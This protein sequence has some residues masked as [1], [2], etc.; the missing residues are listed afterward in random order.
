MLVYIAAERLDEVCNT[1]EPWEIRRSELVADRVT[2]PLEWTYFVATIRDGA[3]RL[4]AYVE[5]GAP[6]RDDL[7][8]PTPCDF[9]L[10]PL[11][12][13][14]GCLGGVDGLVEWAR[15]P[16]VLAKSDDDLLRY[17]LG[18]PLDVAVQ[19]EPPPKPLPKPT[20]F[21]HDALAMKLL[22]AVYEDPASDANR[23]VLA[24]RLL[25]LGDPRGE[26]IALQ[27]GR[28]QSGA[29]ASERERDLIT[30]YGQIWAQ[31]IARCLALYGFRR[32]F[33][34]TAVVA[35][36]AITDPGLIEHPAWAT[37]EELETRSSVFVYA[38]GMRGVRRLATSGDVLLA[39]ADGDHEVAVEAI[40]GASIPTGSGRFVQGGVEILLSRVGKTANLPRLHSMSIS[41]EDPPLAQRAMQF[42]TS[43][44]GE[45][46]QHVELF[47][48][49]L[50][51]T[52]VA[53]WR[54]IYQV[55]RPLSLGLRGVIDDWVVAIVRQRGAITVQLGDSSS[56]R[57]PSLQPIMRVINAL[58]GKLTSLTLERVGP[59]KFGTSL[60]PVVAELERGFATVTVAQAASWRSP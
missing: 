59:D 2:R 41:I 40:V 49:D 53:P 18:L 9:D 28:V 11:L 31:P 15:W 25:D 32:G 36:R 46:L 42:L 12:P 21:E 24:D 48:Q 47:R 5:Q 7:V 27:L 58:A 14:L 52:D 29:P 23:M 35:D 43:A 3:A 26:M 56:G 55:N 4:I 51:E 13:R 33:V 30:Q 45:R 16:R 54:H 38:P 8:H 20:G 10:G 37:V 39:I 17:R 57:R 6:D 22:A 1:T 50:R 19:H 34:G 60:Q 44:L